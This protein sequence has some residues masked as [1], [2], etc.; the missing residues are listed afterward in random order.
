MK[1]CNPLISRFSCRWYSSSMAL[2]RSLVKMIL[3]MVRLFSFLYN[4]HTCQD[5]KIRRQMLKWWLH[6]HIE[7]NVYAYHIHLCYTKDWDTIIEHIDKKTK[8]KLLLWQTTQKKKKKRKLITFIW[9]NAT[10]SIDNYN[11]LLLVL[12]NFL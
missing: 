6:I 1:W 4:R 9:H 10:R 2:N 3:L 11:K 12:L 5:K 8:Q 7:E